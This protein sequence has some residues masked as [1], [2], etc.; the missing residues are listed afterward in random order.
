MPEFKLSRGDDYQIESPTV[1]SVCALLR[2]GT[3]AL[4]RA[5]VLGRSD[6]LLATAAPTL[7]G[8]SEALPSVCA[9]SLRLRVNSCP[10]VVKNEIRVNSRDSRKTDE[11]VYETAR[12]Q[13]QDFRI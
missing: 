12:G 8:S 1:L 10:S 5:A 2:P 6:S 4:R 11:D 9:A 3:G 7:P 13:F